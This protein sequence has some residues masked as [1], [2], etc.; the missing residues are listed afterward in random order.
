MPSS[1]YSWMRAATCCGPSPT[2]AVPAPPRTRPTPAHRLGEISSPA[3]MSFLSKR[4]PCSAAMRRWPTES[5]RAREAWARA[6]VSSSR[7]AIS[8]R[9]AACQASSSV[10][11]T[12][13]CRRIPK[14]SLRPWRAACAPHL[15][16]L[17]GHRRGRLAPGQVELDLLGGEVLGGLR[18]AAEVQRRTRLLHRRIEQ[19]GALHLQVLAV[20]VDGLALMAGAQHR[21]PH[22][23]ELGGQRVALLMRQVQAVAR[24]FVGIAA[25]D[26]V[27][28]Q[29]GRWTGGP[30]SPPCA[31]RRS[32]K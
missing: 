32:A 2:S 12:I 18:G 11:R 3:R 25:G 9:A 1:A 28:Q 10:S 7:C 14:L 27:E 6:M 4:P 23:E 30:G 19:L 26:Q 17:L 31:R 13:T 8:W 16:D 5:K 20:V 24:Q 21:A 15:G 29:R 22:G